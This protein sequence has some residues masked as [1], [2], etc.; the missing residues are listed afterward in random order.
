MGIKTRHRESAQKREIP[1]S[2]S[3]QLGYDPMFV[4]AYRPSK[5]GFWQSLHQN[6]GPTKWPYDN[7]SPKPIIT[8]LRLERLCVNAGA[9]SDIGKAP[10]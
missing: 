1:L 8:I 2:K 5:S 6:A 4:N 7:Y 3:G 10:F 9:V